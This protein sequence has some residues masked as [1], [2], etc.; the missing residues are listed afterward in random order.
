MQIEQKSPNRFFE[1]LTASITRVKNNH[2][3]IVPASKNQML[4]NAV[5][6]TG[7]GAFIGYMS[8]ETAN[9][10][11]Q[12][13]SGIPSSTNHIMQAMGYNVA[14]YIGSGFLKSQFESY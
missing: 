13:F 2:G 9:H 5:Y 11:A 12:A 4:K 14:Y 8:Y 10:M 1:G 3:E 7:Y 6:L